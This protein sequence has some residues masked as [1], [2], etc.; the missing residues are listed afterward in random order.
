MPRTRWQFLTRNGVLLVLCLAAV[1]ALIE[2]A[3]EG[4]DVV[5]LTK[6]ETFYSVAGRRIRY[7]LTASISKGPTV[8]LLNGGM[9]SLEQWNRVQAELSRYLPVVSYDRSGAGF[10]DLADAYDANANAEELDQLLHALDIAKPIVLVSYSSSS[11]MAIVFA[12]RHREVVKGMVFVEPTLRS[13]APGTKSYR[14]IYWRLPV[15]TLPEALIGYTRVKHAI[16]ARN[17]PTPSPVAERSNAV[18]ESTHHWLAV[19]H[20]AMS[21][22]ASADEA[23]AIMDTRP[24]SDL[25]LGVLSSV[26]PSESEYSRVLFGLQTKLAASSEA[27]ILRAVDVD[28]NELMNNP[29]AVGAIVDLIRSI[30]DEAGTVPAAGVKDR[31]SWKLRP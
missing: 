10:S 7:H 9:A 29:V 25:P 24:F 6:N 20:D 30:A 13:K 11:M 19:A 31:R 5:R 17:D 28:H 4:R 1:S 14:R 23:D 2:H 27:G 18:V 12:A 8:V 15:V 3:L 22:D 16:V 26:R 21:F